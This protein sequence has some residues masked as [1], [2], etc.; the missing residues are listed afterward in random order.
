[1]SRD[2]VIVVASVSCIYGL[3]SPEDYKD[4]LL[5]LEKGKAFSREAM[6]KALVDIHYTRNDYEFVRAHFRVRGDVVE[7]FPAYKTTALRVELSGNAIERIREINP[8]T[9]KAI[10]DIKKTAVYPA[11]HFVTTEAKLK[12]AKETITEELKEHLKFLRENNKLLEAQRLEMR[13][14]YDLEMLE[15]LG[16]CSGVENYSRHLTGRPAGSRPACLIDYFPEGFITIIDESHVT[17]PQLRGMYLGDRARKETLVEYGFRLPS[18]LDNRPLKFE[19]FQSLTNQT[20]Y[21]SATPSDY[22]LKK[23]VNVIE[24]V[25]RPTGLLDPEI[26][27][28]PTEGQLDDLIKEIKTRAK[29]HERILVTTLTKRMSE[30][31]A[32]YLRETGI[33]VK[34]LHSE[35]D[36]LERVEILRDLRLRKFDCLVG[37]NLLR[38]GLDLPEVS[39]VAV[40]DADK[41]GFLR[42]QTSLIQVGGRAA[43]NVNGSVILYADII[44]G[45]MK[46]A[47]EESDRRRGIQLKYNKAHKIIPKTIKRAVKEGVESYRKAKELINVI[48]GETEEAH[49]IHNLVAEL[50]GDMERA[51]RNLQFEKAIVLRDQIK[52]L[53]KGYGRKDTKGT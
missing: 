31:F 7:I 34:Y 6:L 15:E 25:I 53:K 24:Q 11:K 2:D 32:M 42:S 44:T 46:R 12:S 39:L 36:A 45:S 52:K 9:G 17:L 43:R 20:I 21:V 33:K 27:I 19:E 51:A 29:K 50:Q 22:E 16:Y 37:I 5:F 35:I 48:A 41:E 38:E 1:M 47:I 14:K 3:G 23:S 40:L 8:L 26:I 28:R 4:Q 30:D 10:R 49:E 13:A 18:A